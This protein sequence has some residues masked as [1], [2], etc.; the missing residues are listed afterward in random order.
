MIILFQL[1]KELRCVVFELR[2]QDLHPF[3]KLSIS[4]LFALTCIICKIR[5]NILLIVYVS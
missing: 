2:M 3:S 1:E 4:I 5:V